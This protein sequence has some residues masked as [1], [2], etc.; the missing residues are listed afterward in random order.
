MAQ[1]VSSKGANRLID[2]TAGGKRKMRNV[3]GG[4]CERPEGK[5]VSTKTVEKK[6]IRNKRHAVRVDL[7]DFENKT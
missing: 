4:K 7:S 6:S 3:I 2:S 5:K 1:A